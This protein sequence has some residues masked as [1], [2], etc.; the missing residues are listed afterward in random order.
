MVETR[1][2]GAV[3][4]IN[5]ISRTVCIVYRLYGETVVLAFGYETSGIF[6]NGGW[7]GGIPNR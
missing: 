5:D 2:S 7:V 6:Q 1:F 3:T 4:K